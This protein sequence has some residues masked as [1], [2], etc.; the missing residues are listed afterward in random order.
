[1]A[2]LDVAKKILYDGITG[3]PFKSELFIGI[4]YYNRLYH[5]VSNKLQV[6]SRG[7]V[8]ILTHQPTEGKARQGGLRFGEME[9]DVL[10]GYG[11]SLLLKERLLRPKRQN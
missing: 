5:M 10:V 1:M 4:A 3:E 6:R 9:R 7:P 11:A 8:Q 2:S